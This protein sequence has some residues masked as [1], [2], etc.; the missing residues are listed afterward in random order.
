MRSFFIF[1]L[2]CIGAGASSQ[3]CDLTLKG[4]VRDEDNSEPLSFAVA[5]HMTTGQTFQCN[6]EGEFKITGLCAGEHR[7]LVQHV[8][9][10]DS[11]FTII[12]T[13]SKRAVFRLPHHLNELKDVEVVSK[14]VEAAPMQVTTQLD[15]KQLDR[16]RG[17]PLAVQLKQLNG[18]TTFNNGPSVAKPVV[19]G[20]QGYRVL[21]LNN[22][23][24]HEAQQWGSEHAPEIDPFAAGRL[25]LLRGAGAVRYGSDAI[26]GVI[27]VEPSDLPD[28]SGIAG[29]ANVSGQSNG[30]GG[31][32]SLMLEGKPSGI[33]ALAWRVQG[34]G[35]KLGSFHTPGYQ[36]MNTGVNE[37]DYSAALDY[38]RKE[39]GAAVYYSEFNTKFGIFSGAHAESLTDLKDA[40]ARSKPL[41]SL[42]EFSYRFDRPYQSAKHRLAKL[43]LD[44]HTG[45]RARVNLLYAVQ[46]NH[47]REFDHD[48]SAAD[49]E[50]HIVSHNA[51]LLWEHDY[52]RS[53]RGKFGVQ[54]LYQDNTWAGRFF[55]PY[56]VSQTAGIFAIERFVRPLFE[57]EAGVRYDLKNLYAAYYEQNFLVRP[58]REFS[59]LSYNLGGMV[60]A[61]RRLGF[62]LN[63]ASGWRAPAVNELYS[64]GLHHGVGAIERGNGALG[65]EYCHSAT[66]GVDARF[67]R[68]HVTG[69]AYI[70]EFD[71]FIYLVPALRPELTIRG[72]FPVF[73]YAQSNARITGSDLAVEW[74]LV[75]WF[76]LGTKAMWLKGW[77]RGAGEPLIYMPPA[78]YEL[79]ARFLTATGRRVSDFYF[80]P[81][82][83]H[84]AR[85]WRVPQNSDFA[86]PP[87]AYTLFGLNTSATFH[88]GKQPLIVTL[89]VS[90]AANATYRDYLDRFR[91]YTDATGSNY[92]LKLRVPF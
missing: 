39:F 45:P 79:S 36:M 7:I 10:G 1:L 67:R 72:A 42:A 85:Q 55:I 86:P 47:R 16:V 8:G 2:A 82:V 59:N 52:I 58:T 73:N 28:S 22:G 64:N 89:S 14:H 23:V 50:F 84:V 11:V 9:C 80:E 33:R 37:S 71:N 13:R 27:L 4:V 53:F 43:Q 40:L 69:S 12:L 78:R 74:E 34:S 76:A 65:S 17:E 21:I 90:N 56:Y 77:N 66:A 30:R 87:A 5:K 62:S 26:A 6:D 49:A 35:K 91:Y 41:D 18:V 83:V 68:L 88:A 15:A 92:S 20:M 75:K 60:R 63:L 25:T 3:T 19:N 31:A 70:Y 61:G 44:F 32:A 48:G 51:E 24:R 29:E 57:I 46:S 38:H 54:A 81:A